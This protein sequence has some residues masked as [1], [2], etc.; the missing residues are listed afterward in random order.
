MNLNGDIILLKKSWL[1]TSVTIDFSFLA[2]RYEQGNLDLNK[3]VIQ[4]EI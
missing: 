2:R 1:K 3:E 4:R